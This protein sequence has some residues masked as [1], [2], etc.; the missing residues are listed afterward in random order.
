MNLGM[1]VY[2]QRINPCQP[3]SPAGAAFR[4]S[5][6]GF[7]ERV[8]GDAKLIG[9]GRDRGVKAGERVRDSRD[10]AGGQFRL[11]RRQHMSFSKSSGRAVRI[12]TTPYSFGPIQSNRA[13]VSGGSCRHAIRRPWP[14]ATNPQTGHQ[15]RASSVSTVMICSRAVF[16]TAT[17]WMPGTSRRESARTHHPG[18]QVALFMSGFLVKVFLSR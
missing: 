8:P 7:P 18:Q 13:T 9:K 4:F 17:T 5:F 11:R 3:A 16:A 6:H 15:F 12:S 10:G 14:T 1:L 2:I